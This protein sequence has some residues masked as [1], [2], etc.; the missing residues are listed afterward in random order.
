M[1]RALG[2]SARALLAAL[3]ASFESEELFAALAAAQLRARG[4][5]AEDAARVAAAAVRTLKRIH[6][7]TYMYVQESIDVSLLCR[8]VCGCRSDDSHIVFLM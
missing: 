8:R 6:T 3:D 1:R 2:G 7:V 5:A 4:A